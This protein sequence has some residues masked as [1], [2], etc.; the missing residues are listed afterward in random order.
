MWRLDFLV[1]V[2]VGGVLGL[3]PELL[4]LKPAEESHSLSLCLS[5]RHEILLFGSTD[6]IKNELRTSSILLLLL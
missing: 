3:N 5:L 1:V 4:Y 2:V 6:S